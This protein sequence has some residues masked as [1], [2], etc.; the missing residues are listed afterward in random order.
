MEFDI[1]IDA[2]G[3]LLGFLS[4]WAK[5][6]QAQPRGNGREERGEGGERDFYHECLAAVENS[7]FANATRTECAR[8]VTP[9][10]ENSRKHRNRGKK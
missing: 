7:R 4:I 3:E 9:S 6:I 1:R 8:D 5:G 10:L 2:G